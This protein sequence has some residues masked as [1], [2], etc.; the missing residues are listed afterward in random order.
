MKDWNILIGLLA[1]AIAILISGFL[2]AQAIRGAG[3][4]IFHG[5]GAM[6]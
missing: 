3:L 5:L 1:I 4:N 2:I 6:G